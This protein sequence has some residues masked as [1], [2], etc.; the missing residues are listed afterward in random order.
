MPIAAR[1]VTAWTRSRMVG[2]LM[3]I[4]GS[5]LSGRFIWSVPALVQRMKDE[6]PAGHLNLV[7]LGAFFP[8]LV[9]IAGGI[10][11]WLGLR[12]LRSR[13]GMHLGARRGAFG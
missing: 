12:L 1:W 10:L 6:A 8:A 4:G 5:V 11:V 7:L 3:V 9:G 2:L 13:R